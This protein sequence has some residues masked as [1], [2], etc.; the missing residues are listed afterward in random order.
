MS[1]RDAEL[2]ERTPTVGADL[3]EKTL[4]VGNTVNL[5]GEI[6]IFEMLKVFSD[7][8]A[9]A[10]GDVCWLLVYQGSDL[11]E[12]AGSLNLKKGDKVVLYQDEDDFEVTASLDFRYVSMLERDTWVAIPDWS[13]I[14]RK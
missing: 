10:A 2:G 9:I 11:A 7:F 13:T 1:H 14:L 5:L 3:G 6:D 4:P 12:Q 8:N